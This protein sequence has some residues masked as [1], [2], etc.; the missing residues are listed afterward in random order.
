LVA[1]D[2]AGGVEPNRAV[3]GARRRR[4]N[5]VLE[6]ILYRALPLALAVGALAALRWSGSG[7]KAIGPQSTTIAIGFVLISAFVGGKVAV[8]TGLPRITGYLVV[9]V[10]VGPHVSGL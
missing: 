3:A 7:V 10:L 8:R 5:L 2:Q 4:M 6:R 9:G 1:L